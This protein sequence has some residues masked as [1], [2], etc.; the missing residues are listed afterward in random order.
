M[1]LFSTSSHT[2]GLLLSKIAPLQVLSF[3]HTLSRRT[4]RGRQAKAPMVTST[5]GL[6]AWFINSLASA[7]N[8][9]KHSTRSAQVQLPLQRHCVPTKRRPG[10]IPG[11]DRYQHAGPKT[12]QDFEFPENRTREELMEL[13]DQYSGDSFT[14]QLPLI[15]PPKLYQPSDGPHLRVSD[16]PEDEWPPPHHAWPADSDTKIKIQDLVRALQDFSKHPEDIYQLYRA[17]PE[18]RAPYLESKTRHKMLRHLAVVE[19]KDERSMLRYLS[20]IDDVKRSAIPLS[21]AEWTSAVSFVARYVSW[22]TEVEVEAALHMWREM[23]HVAG[24]RAS[25]ATFNVLFDVA[26]KAGKFTLAEMIY[27]EMESRGLEFNRYHHVS[28]IFFYGLQKNGDGA[29]AAYKSLVEAGE[30]VDTVVLNAMISA[31][32]RAHEPTAAENVYERMKKAHSERSGSKLQPRNFKDRR[33]IT[34]I[35]KQWAW[36]A[37]MH[38][39]RRQEYQSRSII[40]PDLHTFRILVNH[41]AIEAGDL[42]KTA[43]FLAEMQWF[44]LPLHGALFSTLLKGF[45][46]HG[47]VRYTHWTEQ[48]LESVWRSLLE[49]LDD[50]VEDLYVSKWMATWALRAFAKCSGKSRTL[51][52]WDELRGKW[53]PGEEDMTFVMSNLRQILESAD[54]AQKRRDW[55]IGGFV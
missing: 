32:F 23:E 5:T 34:R 47:G 24:V 25:D 11:L 35:L 39:D 42:D 15:D 13:V 2:S 3:A 12:V 19:R 20:V 8:C 41:F 37:K 9:R 16:K 46:L 51:I 43:R 49:A 6:E 53:D 17:L 38:P 10:Y 30:I 18:P 52:A 40:A 21:S 22:S 50:G 26:C 45:A 27:K 44:R 4:S 29:R 31:L 28:M 48:R 7:G 54:T 33:F 36:I 1:S 55:V 14:D